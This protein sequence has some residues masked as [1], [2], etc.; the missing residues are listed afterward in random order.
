MPPTPP[1]H[2]ILGS[3]VPAACALLAT[4]AQAQNDCPTTPTTLLVPAYFYPLPQ[5]PWSRLEQQAALG[6]PIVAIMN[7]A[8]GPGTAPDPGYTLEAARARAAGVRLIAYIPT[9]YAARPAAN[10]IA[11]IQSYLAFYGAQTFTGI[12][13]DEVSN[14][15]AALGY[16]QTITAAARSLIPSA[17]VVANPGTQLPEALARPDVA[18]TFVLYENDS[19]GPEPFAADQPPAWALSGPATRVAYIVYNVATDAQ[20]QATLSLARARNAGFVFITDDVLINPYDTLPPY[21]ESQAS[22]ARTPCCDPIDFNNDALFPDTTDIDDFLSVF[23]GGPC[24]TGTCAD[25]DFNNDDLFP[26][27]LDIDSL[28]SVFSGGPCL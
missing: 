3:V 2:A 27:T 9:S 28:L 1:T 21:W 7:P 16:Y 15:P 19:A 24:S 17:L 20:M 26:D 11:D 4:S 18:D 22:L 12:F 23:S 6:T 13:W 14:D 5:S 10:V 25:I 8:S